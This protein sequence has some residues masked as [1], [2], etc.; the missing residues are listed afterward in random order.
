MYGV[1]RRLSR[2]PARGNQQLF[3]HCRCRGTRRRVRHHP[4]PRLAHLP[5]R[6]PREECERQTALHPCPCHRLRPL[7][8][9]GEPHGLWYRERR[10]GQCR[11]HH[12]RVGTDPPDRHQPLPSGSAQVLHRSQCRLSAERRAASHSASRPYGQGEGRHLPRT[13]HHAEGT[14]VLRRGCQHGAPP[15]PQRAFLLCRQRRHDGPDDLSRC[16]AR[17]C[18]PLPLP[19]IHARQA[20]IRVSEKLRC[21][22]HAVRQ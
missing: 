8:R 11:L 4:R 10:Y 21:L 16:R 15:H 18:R 12:V 13:Y 14:G 6:H 7:S 17:H 22:R 5:G 9:Q 3:G 2:Q 20:G 1:C 19:R